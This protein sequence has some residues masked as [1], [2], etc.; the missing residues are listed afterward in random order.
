VLTALVS[1]AIKKL[2]LSAPLGSSLT[3]H[4]LPILFAMDSKRADTHLQFE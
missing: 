4:P 3:F 2:V 1:A